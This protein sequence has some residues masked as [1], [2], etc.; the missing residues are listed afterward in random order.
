[1]TTAELK[2][3]LHRLVVETDN[4]DV[5]QKIKTIFNSLLKGN[6]NVDWWDFISEQE[7]SSIKRG[8]Q[9]LEN[10]ERIS[11]TEVRK[12]IDRMLKKS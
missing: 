3:D 6:Q 5:L 12:E 2:N 1:M 8:L 7:K 10:G 11:H 4:M 9:Q